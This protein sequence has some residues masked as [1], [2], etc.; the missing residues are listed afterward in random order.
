M[1]NVT[2]ITGRPAGSVAEG[3]RPSARPGPTVA[4]ILAGGPPDA[5]AALELLLDAARAEPGWL[6]AAAVRLRS[7]AEEAAELADL[8]IER[9]RAELATAAGQAWAGLPAIVRAALVAGAGGES[10]ARERFLAAVAPSR[11]GRVSTIA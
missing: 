10:A 9:R 7:A 6:R 3:G 11:R 1:E 2:S 5:R 8:A 4:S